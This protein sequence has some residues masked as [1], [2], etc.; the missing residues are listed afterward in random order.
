MVKLEIEIPEELGKAVDLY[1]K[2]EK[3]SINEAVEM[4]LVQSL[5]DLLKR[6]DLAI[7]LEIDLL[8]PKDIDEEDLEIANLLREAGVELLIDLEAQIKKSI[9]ALIKKRTPRIPSF[10]AAGGEG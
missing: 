10:F 3:C 4:L 6:I 8:H 7:E 9:V 5:S 1:A 2:A